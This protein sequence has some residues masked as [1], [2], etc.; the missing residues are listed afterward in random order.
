MFKNDRAIPSPFSQFGP[1][2]SRVS[3]ANFDISFL[4]IA[5]LITFSDFSLRISFKLNCTL[6]W[7]AF[8]LVHKDYFENLDPKR[9]IL[10][11]TRTFRSC[12]IHCFESVSSTERYYVIAWGKPALPIK[13]ERK[14][15][16]SIFL[17]LFCF[18]LMIFKL[19]YFAGHPTLAVRVHGS[20]DVRETKCLCRISGRRSI[21]TFLISC[22]VFL[23]LDNQE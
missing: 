18:F 10:E 19:F 22:S 5:A 1:L 16:F 23:I 6:L 12:K 2:Y 21:P 13:I 14:R 11:A 15:Q 8:W 17:L 7:F 4:L 3:L 20:R 9:K